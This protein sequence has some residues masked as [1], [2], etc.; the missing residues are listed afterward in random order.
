[1]QPARAEYVRQDRLERNHVHLLDGRRVHLPGH[2]PPAPAEAAPDVGVVE[3]VQRPKRLATVAP[4]AHLRIQP[5]DSRWRVKPFL[6]KDR[7]FPPFDSEQL[8]V[9]HV[10]HHHHRRPREARP[11]RWAPPEVRFEQ[12][13]GRKQVQKE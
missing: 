1:M 12:P 3:V 7:G 2:A 10:V 11:P 6:R 9:D 5:R 8:L 4:L 13:D